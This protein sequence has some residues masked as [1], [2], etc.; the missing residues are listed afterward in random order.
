MNLLMQKCPALM[1]CASQRLLHRCFWSPFCAVKPQNIHPITHFHTLIPHRLPL[2]VVLYCSR[3]GGRG[4]EQLRKCISNIIIGFWA[5]LKN[6][7]VQKW[8]FANWQRCT[9]RTTESLSGSDACAPAEPLYVS[10]EKWCLR[11]FSRYVIKKS[12]HV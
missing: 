4:R 7:M 3:R 2:A 8:P 6:W 11:G 12:I 10:R 1:Q 9:S 5:F